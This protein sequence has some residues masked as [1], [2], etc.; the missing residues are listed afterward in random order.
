MK[1]IWEKNPKGGVFN[2]WVCCWNW[3]PALLIWILQLFLFCPG[4]SPPPPAANPH[5]CISLDHLGT[6]HPSLTP[7]GTYLQIPEQEDPLRIKP[8]LCGTDRGKLRHRGDRDILE[9]LLR[10]C[11]W[12]EARHRCPEGPSTS[13][14]PEQSP[15]QAGPLLGPSSLRGWLEDQGQAY[16]FSGDGGGAVRE[17]K[18]DR[19]KGK[20][21]WGWASVP[22][23]ARACGSSQIISKNNRGKRAKCHTGSGAISH[24]RRKI[25]H[26]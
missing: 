23:S 15:A 22:A 8:H 11:S 2:G 10:V 19:A 13:R 14:S 12:A 25:S 7:V 4:P 16:S 18:R 5:P 21:G 6:H 20:D 26:N 24:Q 17:R 9:A 3:G 1:I